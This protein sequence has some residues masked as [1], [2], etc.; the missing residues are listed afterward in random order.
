VSRREHRLSRLREDFVGG[1]SHELRT[2]LTQIR[3]LSELLET[4]SFKSA[5]ERSRAVGVIHRESLRLTNLVDNVL[6]FSRLRRSGGASGT[7]RISLGEVLREVAESLAPLLETLGNRV[8]VIAPDDVEVRGD[9][10]ALARV[11]RNLIENAAKYGPTPQTIHM[12]ATR[13]SGGT[14]RVTVDDEGPGIPAAE[15]A[16]IWQPYYRLDRDRN[17]PA[18]GSGLGLSVVAEVVRMLGGTVSVADAPS[19]KGGARFTVELP[20][21]S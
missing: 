5:A 7:E 17:A 20:G 18:G 4:D 3:M 2:P 19:G 1:V 9:R 12:T 6:E 10:D 13:A 16:R 8:E 14:A 11:F 21:V 15:R